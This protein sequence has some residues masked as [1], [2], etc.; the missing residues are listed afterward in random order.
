MTTREKSAANMVTNAMDNKTVSTKTNN[1]TFHI[2]VS[3]LYLPI[4]TKLNQKTSVQGMKWGN[5]SSKKEKTIPFKPE[6]LKEMI[7][8]HWC[9]EELELLEWLSSSDDELLFELLD[10]DDELDD[11]GVVASVT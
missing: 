4:L 5:L 11:D 6:S 2:A 8:H 7:L 1:W 10:E 9:S 3:F